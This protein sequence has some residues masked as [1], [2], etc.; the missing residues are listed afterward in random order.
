MVI[1]YL[2]RKFG[3]EYE[4]AYSYVKERRDRTKPRKVFVEQLH[5][6]IAKHQA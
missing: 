3:W 2:M 5:K 4:K 6:C 1:Y